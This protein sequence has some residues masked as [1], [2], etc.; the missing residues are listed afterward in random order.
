MTLLFMIQMLET[1]ILRKKL[2]TLLKEHQ[3]SKFCIEKTV[4]AKTSL[5]ISSIKITTL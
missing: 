4:L 1:E 5:K 2:E 3:P